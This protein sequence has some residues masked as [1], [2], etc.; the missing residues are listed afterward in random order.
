M[1]IFT[2][3]LA[4][5]NTRQISQSQ[6]SH[7]HIIHSSTSLHLMPVLCLVLFL[8]I[9]GSPY[10]IPLCKPQTSEGAFSITFIYFLISIA[11][12]IPAK[13]V[14]DFTDDTL[15]AYFLINPLFIR[16][17]PPSFSPALYS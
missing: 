16:A 7:P 6:V 11:F 15:W 3:I 10:L 9:C 4:E 12:K 8:A 14:G 17:S 13:E 1:H 5:P 2:G